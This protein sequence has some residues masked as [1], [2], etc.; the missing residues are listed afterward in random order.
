VKPPYGR[1]T[2]C[3]EVGGVDVFGGTPRPTGG[4]GCGEDGEFLQEF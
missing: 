3:D 2:D 4:R 1:E